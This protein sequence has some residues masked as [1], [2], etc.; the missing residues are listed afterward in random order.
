[1]NP[2]HVKIC[3]I[4]KGDNLDFTSS[5]KIT[6]VGFVFE[7]ASSR[8]V[9]PY[10]A[11]K[12]VS[13]VHSSCVPVGVFRNKD[14]SAVV[15]AC[16]LANIQTVQLHGNESSVDCH[17]LKSFGLTVWKCISIPAFN[18]DAEQILNHAKQ[19]TNDV[20][21]ILFDS[22]VRNKGS[23]QVI[24]GGLGISFSWSMLGGKDGLISRLSPV[25]VWVAGGIN[26]E[27]AAKLLDICDPFG[28]DISSGVEHE[29]RKSA[30][31]IAEIIKV[32]S[33]GEANFKYAR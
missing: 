26:P 19:Y 20:D 32:V 12:L 18:P 13:Q 22:S 33:S 28:I 10:D 9:N 24:T 23:S 17:S 8:Y 11:Q 14:V 7:E 15:K 3:G 29:G 16:K 27:N 4:R 1:M 21:A 6:H 30:E 5:P 31:R 25:N 2:V